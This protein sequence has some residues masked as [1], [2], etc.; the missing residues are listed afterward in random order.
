MSEDNTEKESRRLIINEDDLLLH[1]ANML[2]RQA[3]HNYINFRLLLNLWQDGKIAKADI[4]ASYEGMVEI[5]A[6]TDKFNDWI[7]KRLIG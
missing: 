5:N 3:K 2:S 7:E 6:A 4:D 1:L